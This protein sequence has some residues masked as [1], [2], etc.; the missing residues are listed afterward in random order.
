MRKALLLLLLSAWNTFAQAPAIEWQKN[1]GGTGEEGARK[2]VQTSDGG[3]IMAGTTNSNDLDALGN[4]GGFDFLVTKLD[5]NGNTQWKKCY[6]G[7]DDDSALAIIQTADGGYV[8]AGDT[9]SDN[10]D[11]HGNTLLLVGITAHA[12]IIKLNASGTIL[13]DRMAPASAGEISSSITALVET[14]SG[15]I[16][17]VGNTYFPDLGHGYADTYAGKVTANGSSYVTSAIMGG[18]YHDYFNGLAP[19]ADGGFIAVG[20]TFSKD[21]LFNV[22][23]SV[24]YTTCDYWIVKL[25]AG[26]Q[27]EWQ[28]LYGGQA[29]DEAKNAIQ[30]DQ[31]DYLISGYTDSD[32]GDV[33][34]NHQANFSDFWVLKLNAS[35]NLLWQ[36]CFG[37]SGNEQAY[38]MIKT[39]ENHYVLAGPTRYSAQNPGNPDGDVSANHNWGTNDFWMIKIDQDGNLVWEK[40]FGGTS[41]D[42]PYSVIQTADSGFAICGESF[43]IDGDI[44]STPRGSYDFCLLKLGPGGSMNINLKLFV[45]GYYLGGGLMASVKNAQDGLSPLTEVEDI[46]V[47]LHRPTPPYALVTTTT[48]ALKTDGS[49]QCVFPA[50]PGTYYLV[51]QTR[52]SIQTWSATPQSVGTTPLHYDF[53]TAASQAYGNNMALLESGVYGC[54]SGDLPVSGIHDGFVD[55]SDYSIWENDNNAFAMGAYASDFNGDGVVDLADYSIWEINNNGFVTALFPVGP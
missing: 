21:G 42:I 49:A 29:N 54:Y 19:T 34:N 47:N 52:N 37:G 26:G 20:M 27:V 31:G 12:W 43:S 38:S 1:L 50:L 46:T 45:E 48:A 5:A 33:S 25:N 11:V 23:H 22:N 6:G 30:T 40:S 13:W 3:Y 16:Q 8:V 28:R 18:D 9:Q 35:G 15:S 17:L 10:G 2:I 32:N 24:D 14:A 39:Q 7:T 53:T 44:T 4:H 41:F 51:V 55:L 36:K